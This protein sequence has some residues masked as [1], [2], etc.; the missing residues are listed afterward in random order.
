V[1]PCLAKLMLIAGCASM[2][3]Q[4]FAEP[5][6]AQPGP[7]AAPAVVAPAGAPK[8]LAA[9]PAARAA[10]LAPVFRFTAA[11]SVMLIADGRVAHAS[12]AQIPPPAPGF[13]YEL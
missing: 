8:L 11:G 1:K 4:A 13:V 12:I 7:T 6:P 9:A 10:N 2:A 3:V 5:P